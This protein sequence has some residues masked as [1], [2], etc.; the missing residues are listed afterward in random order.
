MITY[1]LGKASTGK[2]RFA[3]VESD[4]QYMV[5]LYKEVMGK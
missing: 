3:I 5:I 2:F 1:L 4:E